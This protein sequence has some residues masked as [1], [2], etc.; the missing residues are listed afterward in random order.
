MMGARQHGLCV[1][2]PSINKQNPLG[3]QQFHINE[4]SMHVERYIGYY[5]CILF[6]LYIECLVSILYNCYLRMVLAAWGRI[7]PSEYDN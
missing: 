1:N 6:P 4:I 2:Y 3:V 5:F 7:G